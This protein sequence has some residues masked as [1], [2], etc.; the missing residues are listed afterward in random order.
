MG[1]AGLGRGL[2]GHE[3][4][5][6]WRGR[7]IGLARPDRYGVDECQP[8]AAFLITPLPDFQTALEILVISLIATPL[9][10]YLSRM[11]GNGPVLASS[12]VGLIAG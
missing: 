3:I 5:L 6:P 10:F 9:T 8:S 12:V 1:I 11:N 2:H 7:Q 4:A